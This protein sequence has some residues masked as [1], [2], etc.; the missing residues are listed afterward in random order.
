MYNQL[1]S[2]QNQLNG[3][4][5]QFICNNLMVFYSLGAC[6]CDSGYLAVDCSIKEGLP[7]VVNSLPLEGLCD[8][9]QRPCES[10]VVKGDNFLSSSNLTCKVEY[11]KVGYSCKD[12]TRLSQIMY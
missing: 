11:W 10:T 6:V 9:R 2:M 8:M 7:P 5:V 3:F 4:P 1:T 12:Q